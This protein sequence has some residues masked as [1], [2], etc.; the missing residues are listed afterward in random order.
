M[1]AEIDKS[2]NGVAQAG[3]IVDMELV[4][5]NTLYEPLQRIPFAL[6]HED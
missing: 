5:C 1:N 4:I 2:T 3:D 6:I